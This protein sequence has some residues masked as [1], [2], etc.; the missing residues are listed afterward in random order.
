MPA[1]YRV[2]DFEWRLYAPEAQDRLATNMECKTMRPPYY[3]L[4]YRNGLSGDQPHEVVET[5]GGRFVLFTCSI[6]MAGLIAIAFLSG[7]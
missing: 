7:W 1:L 6:I 5:K 4:H 3:L 2:H